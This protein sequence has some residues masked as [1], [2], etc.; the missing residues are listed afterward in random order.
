M[1]T[2]TNDMVELEVQRLSAMPIAELRM[3]WR[4]TFK[5]EP[6]KAFGPDLLRRSLAQKIQED[7]HGG[8]P[9][10]TRK[11]LNQLVAQ[12]VK[13]NGKIVMPRRIKPGAIL[14]REWKGK[15]HRIVVLKE[16]FAFEGRPYSSL[17]EVARLITGA[18]W[19]GPRFFGLRNDKGAAS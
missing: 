12:S 10:A 11:L 7:A 13:S 16:G 14:V 3:R 1:P 4:T 19:N 2:T 17:S 9:P 8:L 5:S 18:R 15:T 6:P